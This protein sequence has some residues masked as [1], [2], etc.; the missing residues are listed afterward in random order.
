MTIGS[1][2]VAWRTRAGLTQQQLAERLGVR[3][4]AVGN[5]ESGRNDIGRDVLAR[6]G[7]V[8]EVPPVELGEALSLPRS[9]LEAA[10]LDHGL[11]AA[12]G[13]A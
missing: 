7:E 11:V 10:T 8:L 12:E 6:I 5:W 1:Q 2:L 9:D 3:Q 13:G 4:S